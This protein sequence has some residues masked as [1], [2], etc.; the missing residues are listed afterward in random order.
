MGPESWLRTRQVLLVWKAC[1]MKVG[2][3]VI[4]GSWRGQEQRENGGSPWLVGFSHE[5]GFGIWTEQKERRDLL[6]MEVCVL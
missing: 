3:L 4:A 5:V 6:M 2:W 1:P